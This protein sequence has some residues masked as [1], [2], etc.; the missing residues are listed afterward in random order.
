MKRV[1]GIIAITCIIALV[2]CKTTR[3]SASQQLYDFVNE[4]EL[5]CETYAQEDWAKS[6][7]EFKQLIDCYSK[8]LNQHTD[9]E[10]EVAAEAIGR[11]HALLIKY[12]IQQSVEYIE[13]IAK[14]FPAYINGF[15]SG[16][17]EDACE[18]IK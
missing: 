15:S 16:L 11:Y 1:Y 12:G 2:G 18:A 3:M 7:S 14:L 9:A 5:K 6:K 10:R 4:T 13:N 8:S 17:K